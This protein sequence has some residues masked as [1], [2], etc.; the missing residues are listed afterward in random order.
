MQTIVKRLFKLRLQSFSD[1]PFIESLFGTFKR[2]LQYPGSFWDK[3]EAVEYFSRY[4]PWYNKEHLHSGIDYVTPE[5][6]HNGQ[7]EKIVSH[8]KKKLVKQRQFR[9]EV[10]RFYQNVLSNNPKNILNNINPI[11]TCSVMIF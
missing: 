7:R 1:N 9:K 3:Q 6:C 2:A 8:R 5:Q 4:F 11:A 10:N